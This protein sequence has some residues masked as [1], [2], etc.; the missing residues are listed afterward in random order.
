MSHRWRRW[1]LWWWTWRDKGGPTALA[2][3]LF[4]AVLATITIGGLLYLAA[5][6]YVGI[7]DWLVGLL[8]V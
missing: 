2:E 5:L 8:G 4:G 3:R 6:L 7:V 1:S